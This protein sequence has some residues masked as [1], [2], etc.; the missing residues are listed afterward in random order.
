M[1]CLG[2]GYAY[3]YTAIIWIELLHLR[4]ESRDTGLLWSSLHLDFLHCHDPHRRQ[5]SPTGKP[6]SY[7]TP[8]NTSFPKPTMSTQSLLSRLDAL[9]EANKSTLQLIQRLSKLTFQPGSTALNGDGD[10]V[11]V[12][13][14]S[15]IHESLR[16]Q[17]QEF[18]LLKQEAE[19]F[20]SV[21]P[22]GGRHRRDSER[23]RER[24]RIS[25][26]VARLGEDLKAYLSP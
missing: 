3:A 15:E 10:D 20:T 1:R 18:E 17:E 22:F 19:D 9:S 12:E 23:D 11:R 7:A 26:Q 8:R 16:Q 5:F 24:S 21:E 25:V 13:L 6:M 14:S 4:R 2:F